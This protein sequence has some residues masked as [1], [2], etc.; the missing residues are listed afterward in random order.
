MRWVFRLTELSMEGIVM[1]ALSSP[2]HKI[3]GQYT[4]PNPLSE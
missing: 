1:I 3:M 2:S 4:L